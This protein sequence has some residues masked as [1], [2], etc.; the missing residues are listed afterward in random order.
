M[1][2][3]LLSGWVCRDGCG[4][5]SFPGSC[6]NHEAALLITAPSEFPQHLVALH[7]AAALYWRKDCAVVLEHTQQ[8]AR[9]QLNILAS[10][11][12]ALL[13]FEIDLDVLR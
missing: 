9:I 3:C 4:R 12:L 13:S 11:G 6:L 1:P 10:L 8:R 5:R 7:P 2:V